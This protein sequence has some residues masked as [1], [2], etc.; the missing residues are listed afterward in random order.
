MC[1]LAMLHR[2]GGGYNQLHHLGNRPSAKLFYL[3]DP[4]E[5][6]RVIDELAFLHNI[7]GLKLAVICFGEAHVGD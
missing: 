3:S 1:R 5:V 6:E 4:V 7:V 2:G